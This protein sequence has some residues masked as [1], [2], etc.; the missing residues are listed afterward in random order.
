MT[1]TKANLKSTTVTSEYQFATSGTLSILK[2][3]SGEIQVMNQHDELKDD[4]SRFVEYVKGQAGLTLDYSRSSIN[5]LDSLVDQLKTL[6]PKERTKLTLNMAAYLGETI[7]R[8]FG[9]AWVNKV[10]PFVKTHFL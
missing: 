4:A 10:D 8:A 6:P 2:A 1:V 5:L 9:G 7:C 3:K